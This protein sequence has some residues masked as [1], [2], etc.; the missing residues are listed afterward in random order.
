M[1]RVEE[2]EYERFH[3]N[4]EECSSSTNKQTVEQ[5]RRYRRSR[6]LSTAMMRDELLLLC[7]TCC[8]RWVPVPINGMGGNRTFPS[9]IADSRS[10]QLAVTGHNTSCQYR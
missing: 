8:V 4:K 1:P 7:H 10:R 3:Q 5:A 2:P 6:S 9:R